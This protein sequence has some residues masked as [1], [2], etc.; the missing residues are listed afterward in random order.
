[1]GKQEDN[2]RPTGL[3]RKDKPPRRR[4]VHVVQF[5]DHRRQ[6]GIPRAFLDGAQGPHAGRGFH[7]QKLA[8]VH[9]GTGQATPAYTAMLSRQA[10]LAH[11]QA[12]TGPTGIAQ[13]RQRQPREGR[14][15]AMARL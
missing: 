2:R 12:R 10:A 9:P 5:G 11:P 3:A 15:I 8:G 4:E 1:M 14:K 6:A 13:G 7:Q